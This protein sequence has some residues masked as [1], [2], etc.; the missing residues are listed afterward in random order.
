M[1]QQLGLPACARDLGP[2]G[3]SRCGLLIGLPQPNGFARLPEIAMQP[4]CSL[5]PLLFPAAPCRSLPFPAICCPP[6]PCALP[7][8]HATGQR[9]RTGRRTRRRSA[10]A[11]PGLQP[12]QRQ[13]RTE[14]AAISASHSPSTT[15]FSASQPSGGLI[16]GGR[17]EHTGREHPPCPSAPHQV[18]KSPPPRIAPKCPPSGIPAQD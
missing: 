10:R 14:I 6:S 1:G 13:R 4:A 12:P 17:T 11:E 7:V 9:G 2:E 5:C 8:C 16:V 15:L 18:S 3:G